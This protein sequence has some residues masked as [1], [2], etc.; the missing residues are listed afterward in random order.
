MSE[1]CKNCEAW[2][3]AHEVSTRL[4]RELRDTLRAAEGRNEALH[5]I[6]RLHDGLAKDRRETAKR[7]SSVEGRLCAFW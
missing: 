2:K 4:I 5:G 7:R 6:I 1:T 3:D